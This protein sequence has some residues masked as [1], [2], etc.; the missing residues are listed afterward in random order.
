MGMVECGYC[1]I[2]P[3]KFHVALSLPC[4]RR[5]PPYDARHRSFHPD[6][7]SHSAH[8]DISRPQLYPTDVP[9]RPH[10]SHPDPSMF[11]LIRISHIRIRPTVHLIRISHIRIQPT[12]H[13][14]RIFHIRRLPPDGRGGRFNFP[15]Q[16]CS[17]TLVTLTRTA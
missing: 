9:P 3:K 14:L 8:P 5:R 12:F 7:N 6:G 16:T 11:Y 15:G 1:G 13:L 4:T 17:D 10:I 2:L